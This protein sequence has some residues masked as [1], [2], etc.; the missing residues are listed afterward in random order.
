MGPSDNTMLA[1]SVRRA[2]D[3]VRECDGAR[4]ADGR[5]R[6][7]ARDIADFIAGE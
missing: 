3:W 7:D 4:D 6:D 2:S 5:K 1:G